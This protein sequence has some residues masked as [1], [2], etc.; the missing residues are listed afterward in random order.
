MSY[1]LVS[2]DAAVSKPQ[3]VGGVCAQS[4]QRI[5]SPDL[6]SVRFILKLDAATVRQRMA[7]P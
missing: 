6:S 2:P 7:R 1:Q 5:T 3:Q 4:F